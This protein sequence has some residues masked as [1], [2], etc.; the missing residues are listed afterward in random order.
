L[1]FGERIEQNPQHHVVKD[2]NRPKT[3]GAHYFSPPKLR[4][5]DSQLKQSKGQQ[6]KYN[7]PTSASEYDELKISPKYFISIKPFIF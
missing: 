7:S 6:K 5:V 4:C 3:Q 2:R 1:A